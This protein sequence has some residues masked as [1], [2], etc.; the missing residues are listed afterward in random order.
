[1][2]NPNY[3]PTNQIC[4]T[5]I[6][7]P[8]T[9]YAKPKLPTHQP[10]MQT[11]ITNQTNQIGKTLITNQTNQICKTLITKPTNR[12]CKTLITNP[13]TEYAKP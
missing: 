11:L 1:M 3:Q 2:Q 7:N 5:L 4:K 8:T 12:I 10:N 9:K 6:T 13:P